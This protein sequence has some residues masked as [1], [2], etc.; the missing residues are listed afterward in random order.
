MSPT[1]PTLHFPNH[2][3]FL[4]EGDDGGFGGVDGDP[5]DGGGGPADPGDLSAGGDGEARSH[6]PWLDNL[7]E[8]IEDY[9]EA[10][11]VDGEKPRFDAKAL[12]SPYFPWK[13]LTELLVCLWALVTR[14]SRSSLQLLLDL[15]RY[16]D[17][18]GRRF[19]PDDVPESAEHLISEARK[20]LP[21][22][23]LVRRAVEGKDG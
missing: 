16:K 11:V 20:R 17:S 15:L 18:S 6:E 12:G 9:A 19:K 8:L 3:S 10:E 21:L 1:P 7:H 5:D 4:T 2:Q 14:P 23:R 22:L 13:D